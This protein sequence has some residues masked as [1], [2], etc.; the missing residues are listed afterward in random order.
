ML[1]LEFAVGLLGL[2]F[3]QRDYLRHRQTKQS[4]ALLASCSLRRPHGIFS[5]SDG[6]LSMI[7]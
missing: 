5:R 1:P 4:W 6:K 2:G 7:A 3:F